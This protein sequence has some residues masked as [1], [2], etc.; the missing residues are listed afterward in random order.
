[1]EILRQVENVDYK[2]LSIGK[3]VVKFYH[4][5]GLQG[6]LKGNT[7]AIVRILPFSAIEFFSMEFYKN[8]FIRDG[9]GHNTFL[10]NFICGALSG[11][12]A[13]TIT[14]PL[15][16]MRTRLACNTENSEVNDTHIIKSLKEL[17]RKEGIKGLY[18]GYSVTFLVRNY[19]INRVQCHLLQ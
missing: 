5:E 13:I 3:A 4:K 15:D 1:M 2:G 19:L 18:K 6:L 10:R 9:R 17:Y 16:L 12:N 11:L 8:F 7:P 14:F